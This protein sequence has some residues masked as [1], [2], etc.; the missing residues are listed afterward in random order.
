MVHCHSH[1]RG[2]TGHAAHAS[3]GRPDASKLRQDTDA[4]AQPRKVLCLMCLSSPRTHC[5]SVFSACSG[6]DCCCPRLRCVLC[7][8]FPCRLSFRSLDRWEI[9]TALG[10]ASCT[11]I[12]PQWDFGDVIIIGQFAGH[13]NLPQVPTIAG[14][15]PEPSDRALHQL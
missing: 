9:G 11:L 13:F 7:K 6:C 15:I 2:C 1:I 10:C 12:C 3:G 4:H 14:S 8:C 5:C